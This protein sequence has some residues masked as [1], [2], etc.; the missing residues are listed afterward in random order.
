MVPDSTA[1]KYVDTKELPRNIRTFMMQDDGTK[2]FNVEAEP[3]DPLKEN[4]EEF[5]TPWPWSSFTDFETWCP[6]C[7]S[8]LSECDCNVIQ[9]RCCPNCFEAFHTDLKSFPISCPL[10][11]FTL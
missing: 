6:A 8:Y 2:L 11:E 7:S 1:S 10:C 9:I 3:V 4:A 5:Q